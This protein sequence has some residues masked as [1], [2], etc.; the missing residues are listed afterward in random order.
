M[1]VDL[2]ADLAPTGNRPIRYS[3]WLYN[4]DVTWPVRANIGPS[5][6]PSQWRF[7]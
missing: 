4:R 1:R 2:T 5:D 6:R 3:V 7:K